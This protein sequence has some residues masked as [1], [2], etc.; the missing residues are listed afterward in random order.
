MTQST[1]M[2]QDEWC[3]AF[4]EELVR[5]RPHLQ[6][7]RTS[8]VALSVALKQYDPAIEAKVAARRHHAKHPPIKAPSC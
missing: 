1:T 5:L 2:T 6:S 3:D 8:R 4:V 7:F